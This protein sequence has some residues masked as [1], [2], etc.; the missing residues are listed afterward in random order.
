L[1][2]RAGKLGGES[3]DSGRTDV[4]SFNLPASE[5]N[6]DRSSGG[7]G[8]KTA[9]NRRIVNTDKLKIKKMPLIRCWEE[10]GVGRGSEEKKKKIL[11]S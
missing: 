6:W 11:S 1:E 10:N 9:P 4:D 5:E 7:Q 2:K 8:Q 3:Q